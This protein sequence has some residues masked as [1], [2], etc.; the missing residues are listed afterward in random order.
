MCLGRAPNTWQLPVVLVT[1]FN[2]ALTS[3]ALA[4]AKAT[5]ERGMRQGD[6]K[7][8]THCQFYMSFFQLCFSEN[9]VLRNSF[10][11]DA[12]GHLPGVAS[13]IFLVSTD[14]ST[15][16]LRSLCM[17]CRCV[18]V[19]WASITNFSLKAENKNVSN[20]TRIALRQPFTPTI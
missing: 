10:T 18:R 14:P 2:M 20:R 16:L 1:A 5:A 13:T 3:A 12:A 8:L 6:R 7:S 17:T 9:Q 19:G 15:R 4:W 11:S